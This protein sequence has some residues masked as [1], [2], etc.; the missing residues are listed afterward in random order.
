MIFLRSGN[1]LL[2]AFFY[3]FFAFLVASMLSVDGNAFF[4]LGI[5]PF[6]LTGFFLLVLRVGV[7][8][9]VNF[10]F[11]VLCM[12]LMPLLFCGS[13][14]KYTLYI[15]LLALEFLL[16]FFLFAEY[17]ISLGV[18][19][20]FLNLTYVLYFMLS[21][22]D[23]LGFIPLVPHDSK[24]S[25]FV[26]LGGYTIET[27]YGI[28][29]STAD[30]DSYSGLVLMWNLFINRGQS[31]WLMIG[32]SA[33]AML[34]TFRFTPI[35]ALL[36]ACLS[37]LLVWNRTLA[38]LALI[39]PALGFVM[40]LAI[41]QVD[42]AAQV[43]L[44][45]GTDWY[46]L[47]WNATHARSSIWLGQIDYYLTHFQF[48]DFF[49]GPLDER[50]TVDFIDGDGRFHK[51][52]YNP[53]NTYL[54]LLFRSSVMFAIFYALFLWGVFRRARRNTFPVL[55]FVS[56]VAYTNA[57]IIGLQN[58]AYLLVVMFLLMAVPRG[59]FRDSY[60]RLRRSRHDDTAVQPAIQGQA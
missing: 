32:L 16:L 57:S 58:P 18:F 59:R 14:E 33:V 3:L 54:A 31:R 12:V 60:H 48:A 39:L 50:M 26:S 2:I 28:G 6:L 5:F 46:S 1:L 7:K 10:R 45:P 37:Y 21:A 51:D 22:L 30:I 13:F 53:H 27:L 47:L 25:F 34:L 44:M 4:Y 52:S 42:P 43:P 23:W 19:S 29:G 9:S 49:Y 55:F 11:L 40:V 8:R 41:L 24:N 38:M 15:R 20:R 35:V 36:A 17:R 56:I